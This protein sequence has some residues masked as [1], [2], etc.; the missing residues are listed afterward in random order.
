MFKGHRYI[1][2]DA[3]VL[4]P[5]DLWQRYLDPKY[6]EFMPKH[7]VGYEG[8]GPSW[9]LEIDVLGNQMPNFGP[10]REMGATLPGLKTAYGDFFEQ[11]FQ[12]EAYRVV[13]ERT[14]ID[15]HRRR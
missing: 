15:R 9:Y 4:E 2:S 6:K 12:P 13:L 10:P 14:G 3:H 7:A 8:E 11:G 5:S 1:D